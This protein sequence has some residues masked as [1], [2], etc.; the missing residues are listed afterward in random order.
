MS[1]PAAV[2]MKVRVLGGLREDWLATPV[3][4][5][6]VGAVGFAKSMAELGA[7]VPDLK[8]EAVEIIQAAHRYTMRRRV[9]GTPVGS[10][11][12]IEPSGKRFDINSIEI[13]TVENGR[14]VRSYYVEEW[15]T[16]AQQLRAR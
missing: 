10:F 11:L 1:A 15:L 9:T 6:G 3:P 5:T 2:D 13:H 12:D 14:I 4:H 7:V 16:A 8:W